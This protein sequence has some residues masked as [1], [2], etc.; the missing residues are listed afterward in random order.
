MAKM[1]VTSDLHFNHGNV[2]GFCKRPYDTVEQMNEDLI[3]KWNN[4]VTAEDTVYVLGDFFM[5]M[6][7]EVEGILKR[8]NG[9]I[10]LIRGNHDTKNRLELLERNGVIIKDIDYV[11][12]KGLFFIMCHFPVYNPDFV[13]MIRDS[14]TEGILL[15]G[16]IHEKASTGYTGEGTYHVGV[17][18]NN[19]TPINIE[20]LWQEIKGFKK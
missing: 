19:Y 6:L 2:I 9:K 10:I 13:K 18:T 8:L 16:H 11:S 17:D 5:G 4:V 14:N 1:F 7:T 15:Y 3:E 12:Y 20:D